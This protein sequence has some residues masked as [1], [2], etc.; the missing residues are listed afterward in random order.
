VAYSDLQCINRLNCHSVKGSSNP[1]YSSGYADTQSS[2]Y[3]ENE[4]Y[5]VS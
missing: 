5:T 3:F 2:S 4:A 1:L